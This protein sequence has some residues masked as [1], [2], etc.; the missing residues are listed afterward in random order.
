MKDSAKFQ[1]SLLPCSAHDI[2]QEYICKSSG[3]RLLLLHAELLIDVAH[4]EVSENI[5]HPD[6]A[7]IPGVRIF[8]AQLY[9]NYRSSLLPTRSP[10]WLSTVL[11]SRAFGESC[12]SRIL[13]KSLLRQF[14]IAYKY[15]IRTI[16]LAITCT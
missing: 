10:N 3:N 13:L 7:G 1:Y 9:L 11:V 4:D 14:L 15:N 12:S 16:K 8:E 6:E 2:V 5:S